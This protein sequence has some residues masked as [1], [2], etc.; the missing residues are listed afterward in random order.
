MQ[1]KVDILMTTYNTEIKYLKQQIDSILNQTYKNICLLISDD[2]STNKE[3]QKTLKE[4]EEKDERIKVY[5][6]DNNLGY[7]KNF[8][9]IIWA[10]LRIL[11]F[12]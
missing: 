4:Y 8:K 12:C 6:Q 1:E 10:I 2:N 11:N 3:V 5:I 9:I 7:I